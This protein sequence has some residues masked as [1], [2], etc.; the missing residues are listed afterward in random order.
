MLKIQELIEKHKHIDLARIHH[1]MMRFYN[2]WIPIEEFK[3]IPIPALVNL[4]GYM[5]DDT[6]KQNQ[7]LK[8]TPSRLSGKR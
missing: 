4:L 3:K 7:Q 1:D 5:Q 6:R 2:G 8:K